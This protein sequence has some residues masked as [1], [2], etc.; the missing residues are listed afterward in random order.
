MSTAEQLRAIV[1]CL[2]LAS[3]GLTYIPAPATGGPEQARCRRC[4][5]KVAIPGDA[6]PCGPV[7]DPWLV[8]WWGIDQRTDWHYPDCLWRQARE[9]VEAGS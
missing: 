2:A 6:A 4:G 8:E 9:L 5:A 3:P 1:D 7:T